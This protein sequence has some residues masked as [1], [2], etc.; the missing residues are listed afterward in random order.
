MASF[1][2]VS[3]LVGTIYDLVKRGVK[4][5]AE[6]R[7]VELREALVGLGEENLTLRARIRELEE[8]EALRFDGKVYWLKSGDTSH[9]GIVDA[10]NGPFC[11]RCQDA[12]GKRIRLQDQRTGGYL[13]A[14]WF[15]AVCRYVY[16]GK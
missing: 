7:I 11:P 15:C 2:D 3:N 8:R 13:P 16:S 9:E 5:E 4:V 10:T 14:G 1:S 12:D 6:Q